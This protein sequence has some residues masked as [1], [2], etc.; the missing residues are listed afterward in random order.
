MNV[1][2]PVLATVFNNSAVM[3]RLP[4]AV[5]DYEDLHAYDVSQQITESLAEID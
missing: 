3:H 5:F 4:G 1:E 2:Q